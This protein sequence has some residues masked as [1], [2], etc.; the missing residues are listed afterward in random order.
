MFA[1]LL[2]ICRNQFDIH[3]HREKFR[4]LG[5]N[6]NP[7]ISSSSEVKKIMLTLESSYIFC[8]LN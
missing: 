6:N 5:R 8:R 7:V 1:C 4:N 3:K 2:A